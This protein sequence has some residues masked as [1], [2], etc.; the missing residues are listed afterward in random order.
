VAELAD[1]R[2]NPAAFFARLLGRPV[3]ITSGYRDPAHN[4][5]VRGSPTSE[6][7]SDSAWDFTVPGLSAAQAVSLLQK[8][9]VPFDQLIN[10]GSHVHFGLGPRMR[11]QVLSMADATT[12]ATG[13]FNP[14]PFLQQLF[15][16]YQ[17]GEPARKAAASDIGRM[18]GEA[19]KEAET[20]G[21]PIPEQPHY[22]DYK[23][24]PGAPKDNPY[25][26]FGQLMPMMIAFGALAT[27][28]GGVAALKAATA[29]M[30]GAHDKDS[31]AYQNA[32]Q[33]WLDNTEM[34]SR[35]NLKINNEFRDIME[36]DDLTMRE[37]QAK[38][39]GLASAAG[40]MA[41]QVAI[42]TGD[43]GQFATLTNTMINAT[44]Q[45]QRLALA[46]RQEDFYEKHGQSPQAQV[47][48]QWKDANPNATPE[49]ALGEL[50]EISAA[51][52]R[53]LTATQLGQAEQIEAAKK[54]VEDYTAASTPDAKITYGD[55]TY[56]KA[57][58]DA[59]R[60]SVAVTPEQKTIND[61]FNEANKPEPSLTAPH[62]VD[63]TSSPVANLGK[64]I[65]LP[66]TEA[67]LV[68]GQ[69]YS[70]A[71]GT[72]KWNKKARQFEPVTHG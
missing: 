32:R 25:Q 40:L 35:E 52:V 71:R 53:G 55:V 60:G 12:P 23:P 46:Q 11:N 15:A 49:Q 67:E 13:G 72:A 47:W 41:Q 68:D 36:R 8:A 22:F 17:A 14:N 34:V 27:R 6:H 30:K 57:E 61:I 66:H 64:P 44:E 63:H 62:P 2:A 42:E 24:P 31:E 10:E 3:T 19:Q 58:I 28:G 9:G 4:A 70:T 45:A 29:A 16:K 65:P 59:A 43:F 37:K 18:A 26:V 69:V 21:P 7:M 54:F 1:I 5:A 20:P 50:R 39:N 38:L 56:T 48:E 51:A 33:E